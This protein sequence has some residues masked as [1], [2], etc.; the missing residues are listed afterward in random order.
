MNGINERISCYFELGTHQLL[1]LLLLVEEDPH[2]PEIVQESAIDIQIVLHLRLVV[3]VIAA[4]MGDGRPVLHQQVGA[5]I[6][7][8]ERQ[9]L[10]LPLVGFETVASDKHHSTIFPGTKRIL[11][12]TIQT[13]SKNQILC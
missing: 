9:V 3:R 4:G 13:D 6:E 11:Y 7:I 5:V 1:V 12:P 2:I 10:Q 8:A